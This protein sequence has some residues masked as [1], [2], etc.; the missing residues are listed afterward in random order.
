MLALIEGL[1]QCIFLVHIDILLDNLGIQSNIGPIGVSNH[2]P[3]TLNFL[4]GK[5]NGHAP[6]I[7]NPMWLHEVKV[8]EIIKETWKEEVRGSPS[9]VWKEKSRRKKW[10]KWAKHNYISPDNK[11]TKIKS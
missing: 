4:E 2:M 5:N 1:D 8:M 11:R 6:F 7:F 3:I 10:K 9:F